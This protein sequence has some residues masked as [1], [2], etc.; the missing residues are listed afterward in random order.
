MREQ[1]LLRERHEDGAV[2]LTVCGELDIVTGEQLDRRLSGL[3]AAGHSRVLVDATG[4]TF[5]DAYGVRALTR[6]R[7]RARAQGG[8]LRLVG[9]RPRVRR[10]LALLALTELLPVYD[11]LAEALGDPDYAATPTGA[12]AA[13]T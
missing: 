9:V 12:T 7:V 10:T 3:S 4:L 6:A 1:L 5:C 13:G 2:V 11:T 8:W